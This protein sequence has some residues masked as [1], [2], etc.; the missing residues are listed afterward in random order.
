[1]NDL[2]KI[3]DLGTKNVDPDQIQLTQMTEPEV[4]TDQKSYLSVLHK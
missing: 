4:R 1:M 2:K 3:I